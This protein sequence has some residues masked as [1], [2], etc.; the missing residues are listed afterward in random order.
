MPKKIRAHM[1][2]RLHTHAHTHTHTHTHTHMRAHMCGRS[3]LEEGQEGNQ[4][5][6]SEA[7]EAKKAKYEH[8]CQNVQRRVRRHAFMNGWVCAM[9]H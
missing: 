6:R 8:V 3:V 2:T 9:Q 5:A 7:E 4:A 1:H